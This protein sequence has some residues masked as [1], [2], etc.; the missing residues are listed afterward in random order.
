MQLASP[1]CPR[2]AVCLCNGQDRNAAWLRP[3]P[4]ILCLAQTFAVFKLK[5]CPGMRIFAIPS[6]D[7]V[8]CVEGFISAESETS[9]F[10][11]KI[12]RMTAMWMRLFW[13]FLFMSVILP[14]GMDVTFCNFAD[15][16]QHAIVRDK[17]NALRYHLGSWVVFRCVV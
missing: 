1:K 15:N 3:E 12:A 13:A 7:G 4:L 10:P 16:C 5:M 8:V 14:L 2:D 17:H 6:H 11:G 9:L